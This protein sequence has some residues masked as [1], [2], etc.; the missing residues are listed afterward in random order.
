MN[1]TSIFLNDQISNMVTTSLMMTLMSTITVFV[2]EFAKQLITYLSNLIIIIYNYISNY[3]FKKNTI[4]I[5]HDF[6]NCQF[7][8]NNKLLINAILYN[9][10][11]GSNYK[12]SNQ[13]SIKNGA[14]EYHRENNRKLILSVLNKFKEDD[15]IINYKKITKPCVVDGKTMD[16]IEE[17]VILESHKSI[18]HIKKYIEIKRSNYIKEFCKSDDEYYIYTPLTYLKNQVCFQ[19]NKIKSKKSF[20]SWFS[21]E[22]HKLIKLIDDFKNKKGCYSLT[23]NVYKLGFLL[24]GIPGAGRTTFIKALAKEMNRSIITIS[25]EK[26]T[27]VSSF[28]RLFSSPYLYIDNKDDQEYCY[29]PLKRRILVFEDIDSAGYIVKKRDVNESIPDKIISP[30]LVL[31]DI[32][33]ALDG[34]CEITGLVYVMTTNHIEKLDPALIRPGRIT[35]AIELKEL[36]KEELLE[37]L[38]YYYIENDVYQEALSVDEKLKLIESIANV[39]QNKLTASKIENYCNQYN[40]ANLY[41]NF[42]MI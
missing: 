28:M 31:G 42:K 32:L 21:S 12:I 35:Y 36:N 3:F 10:H 39:L 1:I 15:I 17:I 8:E 23:T 26:F 25:L 11:G 18:E 6:N 29:I 2:S 41:L 27:S 20:K 40:L 33:N 19:Q 13:E 38:T 7:D 24:Y 30:I 34:I 16:G 5:T 37:M 9:Y 4:S 22:K 14:T